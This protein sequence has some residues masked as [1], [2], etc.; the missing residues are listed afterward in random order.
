V[1]LIPLGEPVEQP[2]PLEIKEE[3]PAEETAEATG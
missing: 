2:E 3:K 1:K